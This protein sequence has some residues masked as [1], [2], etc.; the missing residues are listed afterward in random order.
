[1]EHFAIPSKSWK[2]RTLFWG[3]SGTRGGGYDLRIVTLIE[4]FL[5]VQSA[6]RNRLSLGGR[7][8]T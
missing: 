3:V 6:Q 5:V 1:M 7:D 8:G 4:V 2:G